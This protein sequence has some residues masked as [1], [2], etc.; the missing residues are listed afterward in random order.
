MTLR[1]EVGYKNS[2]QDQF[3]S[4][5][6]KVGRLVGINLHCFNHRK[7]DLKMTNQQKKSISSESKVSLLYLAGYIPFITAP[8]LLIVW[9]IV[10]FKLE[11]EIIVA[12]LICLLLILYQAYKAYLTFGSTRPAPA[13]RPLWQI[14]FNQLPPQRGTGRGRNKLHILIISDET[15]QK[16]V[17]SIRKKYIGIDPQGNALEARSNDLLGIDNFEY[18]PE[19][20]EKNLLDSLN[21]SDAIYFFWTK[22]VKD[23]KDF[24]A[25]INQWAIDNSHKPVLV[26]NFLP[27]KDYDLAFNYIPA[28]EKVSG[29]WQLL[30]RATER[31]NQ[32]RLQTTTFRRIWLGT[33]V[34]TIL[35]TTAFIWSS[36]EWSKRVEELKN[37]DSMG[38]NELESLWA[39]LE[40]ARWRIEAL[41]PTELQMNMKSFDEVVSD[42]RKTQSDTKSFD[43]VVNRIRVS[44]ES[45]TG[46]RIPAE[47][48][49]DVRKSLDEF[50]NYV[51][52]DLMSRQGIEEG[53]DKSQLTFWR[54]YIDKD[55]NKTYACQVAGSG[56][57]D[58]DCFPHSFDI[59][60]TGY[61]YLINGALEKEVFVL[62]R[63]DFQKGNPASWSNKGEVTGYWNLDNNNSGFVEFLDNQ[64][65]FFTPIPEPKK[66]NY[67]KGL[68]CLGVSSSDGLIKSGIC[69]DTPKQPD[70]IQTEWTRNYLYRAIS[71]MQ[72]LPDGL[73]I[74]DEMRE[75]CRKAR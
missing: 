16:D 21:S 3:N 18:T 49:S 37:R 20:E 15:T 32:L 1:F 5:Q 30:A 69:L 35:I 74:T 7:G 33:I 58:D 55:D 65:C 64:K 24:Y 26:V 38:V 28:S 61:T 42:V 60:K 17:E 23:S 9:F 48:T 53:R 12:F 72:L 8:V 6:F 54:R 66:D 47:V 36:Y 41:P 11:P 2:I 44:L 14:I 50:A 19:F 46:K 25:I 43:E 57:F 68:I 10:G 59:Q 51:L 56:S 29:L 62:W 70:F 31:A 39:S 67:R 71:I 22:K 34:I 40:K 63:D 73:L 4:A 45:R 13:P 52:K 27:R 75:A